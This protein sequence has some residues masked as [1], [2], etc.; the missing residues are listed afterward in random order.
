MLLGKFWS[1]LLLLNLVTLAT[2]QVHE[3]TYFDSLVEAQNH[4]RKQMKEWFLD[5]DPDAPYDLKEVKHQRQQRLNRLTK[6]V[7]EYFVERYNLQG[8][9]A[10]MPWP[11]TI[12]QNAKTAYVAQ[13][14]G[15]STPFMVVLTSKFYKLDDN[16]ILAVLAH[17]LAHLYLQGRS[18]TSPHYFEGEFFYFDSKKT[19]IPSELNPI[20]QSYQELVHDYLAYIRMIGGSIQPVWNGLP[21]SL[22][23]SF[24]DAARIFYSALELFY[25]TEQDDGCRVALDSIDYVRLRASKIKTKYLNNYR[26]RIWKTA[27]NCL[28]DDS[29][30]VK[31][32]MD[33]LLLEFHR[34]GT[35]QFITWA[36][37]RLDTDSPKEVVLFFREFFEKA[38]IEARAIRQKLTLSEINLQ[39]IRLHSI[40][41]H[42]DWIS[43][44]FLSD[45]KIDPLEL[46]RALREVAKTDPCRRKKA[47]STFISHLY[48]NRPELCWR[49]KRKEAWN[50]IYFSRP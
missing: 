41:D 20:D 4:Y 25:N 42:A 30:W 49:L 17:E 3:F 40:E 13:V 48:S 21:I 18:G 31:A 15:D 22:D 46:N 24:G 9:A 16:Q 39:K 12:N 36:K 10:Y 43:M 50:D 29:Q 45:Q 33:P 32:N 6:R 47:S 8:I 38:R 23:N 34:Q 19:V 28:R 11:I 37:E 1:L 5:W 35:D 27:E 26:E 14:K 2:A 44:Q 7:H